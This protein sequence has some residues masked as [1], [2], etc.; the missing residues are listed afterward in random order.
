MFSQLISKIKEE[1]SA[2]HYIVFT[3][4]TKRLEKVLKPQHLVLDPHLCPGVLR[5]AKIC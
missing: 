3:G 5:V 2:S 1:T 4:K